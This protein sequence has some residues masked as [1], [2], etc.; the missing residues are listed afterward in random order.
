MD[1]VYQYFDLVH[2][3]GGTHNLLD[4][5]ILARDQ[6]LIRADV[7][8]IADL[9]HYQHHRQSLLSWMMR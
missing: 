7:Q 9:Y 2:D 4:Q 6:K 1:D 3:P 5:Q 8:A